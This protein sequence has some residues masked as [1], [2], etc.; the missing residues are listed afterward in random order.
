LQNKQFKGSIF[1]IGG[2][3]SGKTEHATHLSKMLNWTQFE[4]S[5]AIL[6][7]ARNYPH[8]PIREIIDS[9]AMVPDYIVIDAWM[10]NESEMF[11]KTKGTMIYGGVIRTLGQ[12]VHIYNHCQNQ[13][14]IRPVRFVE[15]NLSDETARSRI[16]NRSDRSDDAR[17]NRRLAEHNG[18]VPFIRDYLKGKVGTH[19][20]R[21]ISTE[22]SI[23]DTRRLIEECV[24]IER[25]ESVA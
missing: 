20:Y 6:K 18:N 13:G 25:L 8:V 15:L 12:A 7:V 21:I 14:K 24:G 1:L 22:G 9:G 19:S 5:A 10:K 11:E 4:S 2:P 23:E 3:G 16:L 17:I